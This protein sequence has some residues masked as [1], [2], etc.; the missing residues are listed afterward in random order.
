MKVFVHLDKVDKHDFKKVL[1]S[2]P[3]EEATEEEIQEFRE[4]HR[5]CMIAHGY[6]PLSKHVVVAE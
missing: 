3:V 2:K 4:Y 5:K 1:S 6:R